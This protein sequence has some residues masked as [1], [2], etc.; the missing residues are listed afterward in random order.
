MIA[1][2]IAVAG[3]ALWAWRRSRRAADPGSWP[4]SLTFAQQVR[5]TRA[6]LKRNGWTMLDAVPPMHIRARKDGI[7]LALGM[8]TAET[9][10]LAT[11]VK[12]ATAISGPSGI[13]MGILSQQALAPEFREDAARNGIYVINPADLREIATHIRRAAFQKK[14]MLEAAASEPLPPAKDQP[15]ARQASLAA[16]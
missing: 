14:R 15:N 10:S 5:L 3:G 1:A 9:L 6:Y 13:I 4:A 16:K 8:H 11:L 2:G 12:D 7:G